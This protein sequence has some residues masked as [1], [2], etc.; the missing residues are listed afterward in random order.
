MDGCDMG[1]KL[2]ASGSEA[3]CVALART[4]RKFA[5]AE[6][7]DRGPGPRHG[8][9]LTIE[10]SVDL[11][12]RKA[13]LGGGLKQ[14]EDCASEARGIPG[15]RRAPTVRGEPCGQEE[16]VALRPNPERAPGPNVTD[17]RTATFLK[18]KVVMRRHED[19][20]NRQRNLFFVQGVRLVQPAG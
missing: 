12:V 2:D 3:D 10:Y 20:K 7:D 1:K 8:P 9:R 15:P 17:K 19:V 5:A 6:G 4:A 16:D 11:V 14:A 18:G 13:V